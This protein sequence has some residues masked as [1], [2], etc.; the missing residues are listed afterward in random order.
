MAEQMEKAYC[1]Q[2]NRTMNIDQFYLSRRMDEYPGG[3][4]PK[5]KKCFTMHINNWEPST[6]IPL[7]KIIDVPYV[8]AEW[9]VLLER[10]GKDPKK[11]STM[12]IFGRY[13]SKMK[14]KQ[15]SDYTFAD[16]ERIAEEEA[17]KKQMAEA[18]SE[19]FRLRN[20]AGVGNVLEMVQ[21]DI[22]L[23][24]SE[25][26]ATL[27]PQPEELEM[28]KASMSSTPNYSQAPVAYPT[29]DDQI[30]IEDKMKLSIKWGKLY[31]TE[32]LLSMERLYRDMMDSYEIKT[33]SHLDYLKMI[34]KTSLKMNQAIDCSDYEGYNKLAKVYD[35][36]MKSAKFT[37]A[38]NKMESEN[39]YQAVCELILMAEGEGF[40]PRFDLEVPRDIVDATIKDMERYLNTLVREEQGLGNLIETA[41]AAMKREEEAEEV[42]L[43]LDEDADDYQDLGLDDDDYSDFYAFQE[44]LADDE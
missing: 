20:S 24:S 15:Y 13:L 21:T 27:F 28:I 25:E 32:E 38:Q 17:K 12:A 11:T 44:E 6:Y 9:D 29:I 23:L 34:C 18:R 35:S 1:E 10:Y 37:A 39:D 42:E 5:C 22:D 16:T 7:L 30:S 36:L 19:A 41:I 8:P 3:I 14:L 40:I 2:C 4:L 26:L 43:D 31:N 33:A